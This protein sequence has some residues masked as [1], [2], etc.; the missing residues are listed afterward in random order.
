MTKKE[1]EAVAKIIAAERP[2]S[3]ILLDRIA[4]K[5]ADLFEDRF[6]GR[7]DWGRFMKACGV[8][9]NESA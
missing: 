6:Q 9:E 4:K 2:F 1:F 7:F 8:T 3:R 5:L